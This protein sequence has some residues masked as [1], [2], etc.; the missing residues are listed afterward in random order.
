M[1]VMKVGLIM[2]GLIL[3]NS[4]NYFYLLIMTNLFTHTV[5]IM[6]TNF[7]NTLLINWIIFST[8]FS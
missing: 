6:H 4:L 2:G 3:G 7:C 8:K 1:C 5:Y